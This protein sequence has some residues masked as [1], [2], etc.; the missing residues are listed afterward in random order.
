MGKMLVA[1]ALIF[2]S[3]LLTA[4]DPQKQPAEAAYARAEASVGPVRENLEKYAPDDYEELNALMDKMRARL[5]AQDY[6]GALDI[7]PQ[8]MS[9]LALAS[10]A[11]G[12]KK[13]SLMRSLGND[14]RTLSVSVPH[15]IN[16]LTTRV[17]ELLAMGNKLPANVHRDAVVRAQSMMA[18]LS[19]QWNAALETA[20]HN[21]LDDAVG[22]A[23]IVKKRCTEIATSLAIKLAD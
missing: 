20:Q 1:V 12:Q 21:N 19:G 7:Q 16:Q 23:Q 3:V 11:A 13:N 18:Q 14:W 8:V 2:T 6:Q 17:N 5:N 4:C 22:K 9:Q 15:V 10:S